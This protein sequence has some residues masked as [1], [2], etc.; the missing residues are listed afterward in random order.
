M[1]ST[2]I[3]VPASLLSCKECTM[4]MMTNQSFLSSDKKAAQ[5]LVLVHID[6]IGPM[7]VEPCSY[8]KYVLISINNYFGYALVV[9]IYNKDATITNYFSHM[10][11]WLTTWPYLSCTIWLW[12]GLGHLHA[13]QNIPFIS[14]LLE[15]STSSFLS[16]P[17]TFQIYDTTMTSYP[18]SFT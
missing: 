6:L 11:M 7:P 3:F 10:I 13:F 9:F 4:E 5:P 1:S 2:T 15:H 16:L 12:E 8:V 17:R 18:L 14:T